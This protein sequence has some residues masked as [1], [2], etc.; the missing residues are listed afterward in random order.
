MCRW[1]FNPLQTGDCYGNT[2]PLKHRENFDEQ[3]E[4]FS[5]TRPQRS[6]ASFSNEFE[7]WMSDRLKLRCCHCNY[8]Y[9]KLLINQSHHIWL[10]NLDSHFWILL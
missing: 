6:Y 7:S 8:P 4:I 5:A 2:Y 3:V 9:A 10:L 1:G